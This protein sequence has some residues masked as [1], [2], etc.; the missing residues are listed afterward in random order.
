MHC[1]ASEFLAANLGCCTATVQDLQIV[2]QPQREVLMK[3]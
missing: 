1:L 2:K 3:S